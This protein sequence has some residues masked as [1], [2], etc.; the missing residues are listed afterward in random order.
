MNIP[1]IIICGDSVSWRDTL[2]RNPV[3]GDAM[4]A[5][6]WELRFAIRGPSSLDLTAGVSDWAWLTEIDAAT[7]ATLSPG[8]YHWQA[9]CENSD[10]Y[11]VTVGQGELTVR[12][13]LAAVVAPYDGRSL[14]KQIID[15]IDAEIQA[16]ATGGYV[17][18]YSISG[19]SLRKSS[20]S[21][22]TALRATYQ[23]KY[24]R[25][26]KRARLAQGRG[27]PTN[28]LALFRR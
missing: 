16:R 20:L 28:T 19:R 10:G 27:D 26:V 4:R 15:A 8:A 23:A 25:E 14:S 12:P 3:T 11:R 7:S 2:A 6:D 17:A 21:E 22:L 13:N 18:E 1:T 24:A 9:Y 5:E